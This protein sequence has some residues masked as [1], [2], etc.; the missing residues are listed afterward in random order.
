[1]DTAAIIMAQVVTD[2]RSAEWWAQFGVL[3]VIV[4]FVGLALIAIAWAA[5]AGCVAVW[6]R[7]FCDE[8]GYVTRMVNQYEETSQRQISINEQ[9]LACN[10]K[11]T[12]AVENL[13][14]A[15]EVQHSQDRKTHRVLDHLSAAAA[16]VVTDPKAREYIERAQEALR[17]D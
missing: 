9:Q 11:T 5:R 8:K 16:R 14:L 7:L 6:D 13:A 10:Q 1:M 3:G 15:V 17:D 2:P 4:F 12:E